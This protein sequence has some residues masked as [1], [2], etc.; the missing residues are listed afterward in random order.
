MIFIA[1]QVLQHYEAHNVKLQQYWPYLWGSTAATRYSVKGE[2]D[3]A[4]WRQPSTSEIFN[5]FDKETV[6]ET[7]RNYPVHRTLKVSE[8]NIC[9][10]IQYVIFKVDKILYKL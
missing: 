5:L 6:G 7:V 4:L 3:T 1:S 2:T 9:A 10:R 8:Q